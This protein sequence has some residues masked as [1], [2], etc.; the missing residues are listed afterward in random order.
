MAATALAAAAGFGLTGLLGPGGT[1]VPVATPQSPS[2]FA[3]TAR[4][5]GSASCR[6][7]V[8]LSLPDSPARIELR[9]FP[10]AAPA[11]QAGPVVQELGERGFTARDTPGSD[12]RAEAAGT[13][14]VVRY[15]PGAVGASTLVR[16]LIGGDVVMAFDPGRD[17]EAVDLV[18]GA[19]FRSLATPTEMNQALAQA[20]E[21]TRPPGC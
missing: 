17:G 6:Y 13:A 8:D 12:P 7:P 10:G 14:A 3:G 15:G 1:P 2:P 21:P 18:L 11:G 16:A 5:T 9:V 20:G 19:D 4:P